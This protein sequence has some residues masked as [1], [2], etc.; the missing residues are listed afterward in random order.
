MSANVGSPR[1][2]RDSKAQASEQAIDQAAVGVWLFGARGLLA[3]E[4]LRL[5]ELHPR[6]SLEGAVS[7]SA[8]PLSQAHPHWLGD[9]LTQTSEE[10]VDQIAKRLATKDKAAVFLALPH[11]DSAAVVAA[12]HQRLGKDF[13]RLALVDLAAD[14]RLADPALYRSAYGHEHPAPAELAGFAYGLPELNRAAIQKHGRAAAAGCFATALQLASAPAA[15][16]GLLD[17]KLPWH[18]FGVTGSSGSGAEPKPGTHHPH[19]HGNLWAYS[20]EG[21]RHQAELVQCLR[22]LG[23]EPPIVFL[24][25]SGPF[26][27][28]IHLTAALPLARAATTQSALEIYSQAYAG[29]AFVEV[30][31]GRVPDLR[32]VA[33]SNRASIGVHVRGSVLCVLVTLDN[34]V[35]GGAGQ[36]LQ[37]M[38]VILGFPETWGLPRFGLGVC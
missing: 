21:H 30:L 1:T 35:K 15:R 8:Q 38:N 22:P 9:K 25:H 32:S 12:L 36:A 13:E 10:A 14:F 6:L 3:G 23:M 33:A 24:P 17:A 7:R 28:G 11:G 34:V 37:C 5:L 31:E 19:R 29:E 20:L 27:R 26:A 2:A 4:L 18:F 16:A